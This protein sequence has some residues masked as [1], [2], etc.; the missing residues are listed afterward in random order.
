MPSKK[1]LSLLLKVEGSIAVVAFLLAAGAV[2]ADVIGREIF[3]QG[4]WGSQKFA[5]YAAVT[6]GFLGIGIAT[7]AGMHI[8]PR[9]AD[10]WFPTSF[11]PALKRIAPAVTAFLFFVFAWY[12]YE[13]VK[14]SFEYKQLTPVLD[15]P[16]WMIQIVLPYAFLSNGIRNLIYALQPELTPTTQGIF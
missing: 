8:R 10:N 13:F 1:I 14:E 6:A 7:H 4:L 3:D 5:V 16:M 9:F 12:A 15:W 2:L 11:E